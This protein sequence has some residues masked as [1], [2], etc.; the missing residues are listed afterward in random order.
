MEDIQLQ[1]NVQTFKALAEVF[2]V[3]YELVTSLNL[4]IETI[5]ASVWKSGLGIK[6]KNRPE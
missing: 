6:G 4:P 2:G 3:V 1:E 5:L